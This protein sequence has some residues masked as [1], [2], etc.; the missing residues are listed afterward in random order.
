MHEGIEFGLSI[1]DHVIFSGLA[2]LILVVFGF[3]VARKSEVGKVPEGLQNAGEA[4]V[5]FLVGRVENEFGPERT[6]IVAPFIGAL[7]LYIL[8]SNWLGL[9]PMSHAPTTDL[10]TTVALAACAIIG[11][12]ILNFVVNGRIKAVKQLFKPVV[13]LFPFKII[14]NLTRILSLSLRLFGNM[15]G[16]HAVTAIVSGI[17]PLLLP[18]LLLLLGGLVGLIQAAVFALLSMAYL[19]EEIGG[20]K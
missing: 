10:S 5:E 12:Q 8:V 14:D 20:E 18:V 6:P 11:F 16:E 2:S 17:V 9:L 7:F 15:F 4:V 3:L 19:A 13:F 1:T